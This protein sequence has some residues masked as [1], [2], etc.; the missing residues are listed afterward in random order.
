MRLLVDTMIALTLVGVLAAIL[1]QQRQSQEQLERVAA[2]QE[3]IRAIQSQALYRAA[4][5]DSEALSN[6]Y[7]RFIDAAWFDRPPRNLLLDSGAYRWV[8]YPDEQGRERFNPLNIVASGQR[9]AF[10]YNGYRGIVRAR[11]PLQAT[12]QATVDLYNLV[13]GT[14]LRVTDCRWNAPG[15]ADPSGDGKPLAAHPAPRAPEPAD[16]ILRDFGAASR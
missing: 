7:S 1:L 5:Q 14:S 6:G 4:I 11:V 8:D 3:A 2:V 12:E 9:G 15:A 13:N 16:A 10:W